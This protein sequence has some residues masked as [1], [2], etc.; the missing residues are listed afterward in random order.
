MIECVYSRVFSN[1]NREW[2]FREVENECDEL[3]MRG[4]EGGECNIDIL[5]IYC[6]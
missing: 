4:E 6:G 3:Y 1:I 5:I 2:M